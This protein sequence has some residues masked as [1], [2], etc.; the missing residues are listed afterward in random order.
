MWI[1]LATQG[2]VLAVVFLSITVMTGFAGHISLCQGAFAAIGAFT[3]YQL[4]TRYDTPVLIGALIGGVIAA[5]VG[6]LLSLPLLRLNGIWIAIATL[7]VRVLLQLRDGQV[8]LGRGYP[9]PT[10]G[11]H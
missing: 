9:P 8:L 6:G 4:A 1:F 10:P 7:V 5:V 3:V 2:V 11:Q